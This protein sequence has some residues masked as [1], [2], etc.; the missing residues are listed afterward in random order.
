VSP[1]EIGGETS[2][3]L[4]LVGHYGLNAHVL[5]GAAEEE[6]RRLAARSRITSP[7]TKF[8]LVDIPL[9]ELPDGSIVGADGS[10]YPLQ[11]RLR[12]HPEKSRNYRA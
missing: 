1:L 5:R 6:E 10:P 7:D 9:A 4:R 11:R 12:N 8:L 3:N 2:I